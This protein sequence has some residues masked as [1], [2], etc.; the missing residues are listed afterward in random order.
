MN[1]YYLSGGQQVGPVAETE[2]ERLIQAGQITP[3]MMVWAEGMANWQPLREVQLG[4]VSA[5]IQTSQV[6]GAAAGPAHTM[7]ETAL[8]SA[9]AMPSANEVGCA[10]CGRIFPVE[11]TISYG[12]IRVCAGCKPLFMQKLA[13]GVPFNA[14]V[15]YASFWIRAGAKILDG[16]V[17]WAINYPLGMLIGF[18]MAPRTNAKSILVLQAVATG[19]GFLIGIAYITF[20]V[21]KY[22]AT[23]GKMLCKI[24]IV[25]ADGSPVSYWKAFG[26]Y[27]AELLSGCPTL[28]IG[29]LLAARDEQ[30]RALHDRLCNTRVVTR[31]A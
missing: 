3:D 11:E 8:V 1:Y 5:P 16:A 31:N 24:K 23:P 2:F 21:G 22:G 4:N 28:M 18:A 7:H 27:W 6:S 17:L 13:E 26:R 30:H 15:T 10:E 25:S 14:G 9:P 29:Y 12:N 20:F 19:I